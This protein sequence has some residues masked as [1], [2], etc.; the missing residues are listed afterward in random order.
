[1]GKGGGRGG[2]MHTNPAQGRLR[3]AQGDAQGTFLS[4][5]VSQ[6]HSIFTAAFKTIMF[7]SIPASREHLQRTI[8][9][10]M[11]PSKPVF[12]TA[13]Q[14]SESNGSWVLSVEKPSAQGL[15]T[16]FLHKG[17]HKGSAQGFP[18]GLQSLVHHKAGLGHEGF[19]SV[20]YSNI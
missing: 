18:Q 17:P 16:R 12:Y 5:I 2:N 6:W 15:R 20:T 10:L 8:P 19:F 1:M 13:F 7:C 3:R 9:K 4:L 14:L 11:Y